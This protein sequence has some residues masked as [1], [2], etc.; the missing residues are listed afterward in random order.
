VRV[1]IT[2]LTLWGLTGTEVYARDLALA[3][4]RRGHRVTVFGR[5][6]GPVV[7]ELRRADVAVTD[8]PRR[9]SDDR[10]D[11]I[12]GHHFMP[13]LLAVRQWRT[14]PAIH[15]CHDHLHRDDRTPLDPRIRRHCGVSR[16]TVARLV[17]EGAA[18][19]A[20]HLALNF[21]DVMR[22]RPRTPL[23]ARPRGALVF[24]NYAH[25][26]SHL[27][28]VMEACRRHGLE[29][30]VIGSGVGN[31]VLLPEERLGSYDI[32]FAKAKAAIEAMAVGAAVVLCD[33]A[34]AG[35]L[36]T[37]DN[38]DMLRDMN[39]GFEALNRPLDP[40]ML[41]DEIARY[42]PRDAERVRDR[43]RVEASL[44]H[45]AGV[46]EQL[47]RDVIDEKAPEAP[48]GSAWPL[49][50][51]AFLRLYWA[52]NALPPRWRASLGLRYARAGVR[53]WL[54]AD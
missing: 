44:E 50:E 6:T 30:D 53:R 32:V 18:A 14:V 24:S 5:G 33:Y 25:H 49:K 26:G 38:F 20:T 16:L 10:P 9:A 19:D 29:L 31:T 23:P 15:V 2:N 41:L 1:L 28:V 3:L 46:F 4:T 39:F 21:V 45:A 36:V 13:T 17:R 7:R 51:E 37:S 43:I 34:G 54:G 12:H 22:F 35:P 42:D 48:M 47:Y 11:I 40:A 8:R 52:W 27:P